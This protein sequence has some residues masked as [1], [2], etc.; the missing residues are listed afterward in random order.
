MIHHNSNSR[1]RGKR[2]GSALVLIAIMLSTFVVVV[3]ISVDYAYFQL[4]RTELR[5]V[6]D[7]AAM[8]GA[9][10]LARTECPEEARAAAVH[11]AALNTVGSRPLLLDEWD[12]DVGRVELDNQSRWQ[13]QTNSARPNAVRVNART[14]EGA[15]HAAIPLFFS[16]VHGQRDVAPSYTATAGQNEVEVCLAL[17][18]SGSMLFDMSGAEYV[19]PP[20]NPNLSGYTRWGWIWQNHLSPPHPTESRWAILAGAVDLFLEEA[21]NYARP[22][23]TALV[24]W[25]SDYTMPVSPYTKFYAATTDVPLPA[26]EGFSWD[27]NRTDVLSAVQFLG[28]VPMMGATNLSSGL[29]RAVAVLQGPNSRKLANK[30]VILMTDGEWNEG[31]HPRQA[32]FDA[33]EAGIVVHCIMMLTTDQPEIREVAEITGGRYYFTRNEAELRAAFQD[34]ARTL[35]IVLVE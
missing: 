8:A 33:R 18:R 9:E 6:T 11:Y 28:T 12:I 19:Y 29:D 23:R 32:A 25:A 2:R 26:A 30:V 13:F 3:A 35:P 20:N 5:A 16:G 4:V 34:V 1:I 17:D 31:R 27:S 21:G 10:A 15:R 7:A 22:P 24:T 14:G